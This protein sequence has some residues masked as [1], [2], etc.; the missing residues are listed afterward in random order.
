MDF[1]YGSSAGVMLAASFFSLLGPSIEL[2]K[3]LKWKAWIPATVGFVIGVTLIKLADWLL[4]ENATTSPLLRCCFSPD[5]SQI[6]QEGVEFAH[7][8][9]EEVELEE[10]IRRPSVPIIEGMPL[11]K[12]L[13][14]LV[15]AITLH[16]VPEGLAL[17]FAYGGVKVGGGTYTITEAIM[18]TVALIVQNLP[19]GMAISIPLH[20]SGVSR[21]KSWMLGQ[22]SGSVE[23]LGSVIGAAFALAISSFLPFFLAFAAGA[24]I[25]VVVSDMLPQSTQS[26]SKTFGIYGAM[27]GFILMMALDTGFG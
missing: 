27:T 9:D 2:A 1:V 14:L 26:G 24:M 15:L 23:V 21:R 3:A 16:N 22:F 5:T 17:G 12:N 18:L 20:R 7:S 10:G 25:F 19:E 11:K 4:P 8:E 6:A 13:I